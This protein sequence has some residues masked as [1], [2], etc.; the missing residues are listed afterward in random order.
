M[1]H[2]LLV[3][4][5]LLATVYRLLVVVDEILYQIGEHRRV[6]V[7]AVDALDAS[8]VAVVAGKRLDAEEVALV[9][10]DVERLLAFPRL[11]QGSGIDVA[12]RLFPHGLWELGGNGVPEGDVLL[13]EI[14]QHVDAHAE[15][16]VLVLQ[17]TSLVELCG[18][19][20]LGERLLGLRTFLFRGVVPSIGIQCLARLDVSVQSFEICLHLYVL[21]A[22]GGL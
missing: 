21:F 3:E 17:L 20:N 2:P 22:F 16:G 1:C 5:F 6:G 10:V 4:F 8:Q 9:G 15:Q 14:L 7:V 18:I 11:V 12:H 13:V 19:G